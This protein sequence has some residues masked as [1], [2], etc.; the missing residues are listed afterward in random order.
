MATDINT[1][2]SITIDA[3]T[4]RVWEA[5]TTPELIEKWFFGVKTESDLGQG[6][7]DRPSG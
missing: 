7:S 2:T 3:S 1:S 6:K 4:D 5:M